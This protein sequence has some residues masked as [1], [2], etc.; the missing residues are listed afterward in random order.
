MS[1]VAC[2]TQVLNRALKERRVWTIP[3]DP[4]V[5]GKQEIN[6]DI[7]CLKTHI[8]KICESEKENRPICP[9]A[10]AEGVTEARKTYFCQV[11]PECAQS[12]VFTR[13]QR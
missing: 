5:P 6:K 7:P 3:N 10:G 12:S 4:P 2:K 8:L 1:E 9:A 13:L 11:M